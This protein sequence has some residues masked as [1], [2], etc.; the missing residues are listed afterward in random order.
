MAIDI[1]GLRDFYQQDRAA[2]PILDHFASRERNWTNSTVDRLQTNLA[3]AVSRGEV[4]AVFR[5]LE[6]LGCGS[7]KAGRKGWSSRF[8]W[9]FGMVDVGRAAAGEGAEPETLSADE[10]STEEEESAGVVDHRFQLRRELAIVISLPED[11]TK[12]EASR[13]ADFVRTLP[14]D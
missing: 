6:E 12:N 8:E 2:R 14:F 13:L 5:R 1:K 3:G 9:A 4:I 11:L 10:K 7:F